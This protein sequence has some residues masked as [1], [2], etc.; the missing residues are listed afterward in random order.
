M[1]RC[2]EE[3]DVS[4]RY[5][6]EADVSRRCEEEAWME[7]WPGCVYADGGGWVDGGGGWIE[8]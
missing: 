3:A 7:E 2:E 6:E 8:G 5:E 1:R 4:R